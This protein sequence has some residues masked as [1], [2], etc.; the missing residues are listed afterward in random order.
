M[1]SIL[2]PQAAVWCVFA[3]LVPS[4]CWPDHVLLVI[5]TPPHS[6][7]AS[8]LRRGGREG[9]ILWTTQAGRYGKRQAP[10]LPAAGL[11]T[12]ATFHRGSQHQTVVLLPAPGLSGA[13]HRPSNV[14]YRSPTRSDPHFSPDENRWR[15]WEHGST[16]GICARGGDVARARRQAVGA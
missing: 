12:R 3:S 14:R 13:W 1:K 6:H 5:S 2:L 16:G 9:P 4:P 7:S 11:P 8:P 10:P 15:D